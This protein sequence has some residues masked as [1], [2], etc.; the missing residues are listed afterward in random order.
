MVSAYDFWNRKT[1]LD[2]VD[3]LRRIRFTK[4]FTASTAFSGTMARQ[5]WSFI[6]GER[7]DI[8]LTKFLANEFNYERMHLLHA[9]YALSNR[10][11]HVLPTIASFSWW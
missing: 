5:V 3:A 8:E 9:L 1:S 10:S 6:L 2:G 7:N 4:S 11:P